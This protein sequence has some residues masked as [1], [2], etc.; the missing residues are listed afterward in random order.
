MESN[1][2]PTGS[3]L[4]RHVS[5]GVACVLLAACAFSSACATVI[6][7]STQ[8]V[9]IASDPPGAEVYVNGAPAGVTPAFVDVPR[10]D[11]DLQLRL[12]KDGY[13]P[14]VLGLERS[15]SGWLLGNVLLAGF[16]INDYGIEAWVGAMVVYGV[17]GSLLDARSGGAYKRPSLVRATLERAEPVNDTTAKGALRRSPSANAGGAP[18][19]AGQE[20]RNRLVPM[21][22]TEKAHRLTGGWRSWLPCPWSPTPPRPQSGLGGLPVGD[23]RSDRPKP[24]LR[25]GKLR[26]AGRQR[27]RVRLAS[28]V[29]LRCGADRGHVGTLLI[30]AEQVERFGRRVTVACARPSTARS[31]ATVDYPD[32]IADSAVQTYRRADEMTTSQFRRRSEPK[33]QSGRRLQPTRLDVEHRAAAGREADRAAA[34]ADEPADAY[35]VGEVVGDIRADVEPQRRVRLSRGERSSG[36]HPA[37]GVSGKSDVR[38]EVLSNETEMER[39]KTKVR[40]FFSGTCA[41]A[42]AVHARAMAATVSQGSGVDIRSCN[43]AI[44][45][46]ASIQRVTI[47]RMT[48]GFFWRWQE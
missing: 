46:D 22:L 7:E 41:E 1:L 23:C 24:S 28:A 13:E 2:P 10:R 21:Q 12:E 36:F 8:R 42:G 18:R 4:A 26:E 43:C 17:L 14:T 15:R 30:T 38:H 44:M 32:R 47:V 5:R 25:S 48:G 34:V 20:S 19:A 35:G 40:A 39:E 9:A 16:P 37:V 31:P 27:L 3:P 45:R 6:N 11:A 33:T 29:P